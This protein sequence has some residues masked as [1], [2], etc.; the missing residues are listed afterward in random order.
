VAEISACRETKR[1]Y[2]RILSVDVAAFGHT[3]RFPEVELLGTMLTWKSVLA[4]K[5]GSRD[6]VCVLNDTRKPEDSAM[7]RY[8]EGDDRALGIVYDALAPRLYGFLL[9]RIR[10]QDV[11]EDLMQQAFLQIHRARGSFVAGSEVAPWAFSITRRLMI[12]WARQMKRRRGVVDGGQEV[13]AADPSA[14]I[15]DVLAMRE[16]GEEMFRKL[17]ALP[18]SQR[19]AFELIRLDGLSTREAAGVLGTTVAAVKLRAHRAYVALGIDR[20]GD[21]IAEAGES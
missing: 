12:D 17:A 5:R 3:E 13:D 14:S 8:A 20:A 6:S 7:D 15:E 21:G 16:L 10:R 2:D 18:S 19:E 1:Q 11:A 9:K 4:E